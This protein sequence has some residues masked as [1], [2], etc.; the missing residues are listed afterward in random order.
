MVVQHHGQL[1]F[2]TLC[3]VFFVFFNELFQGEIQTYY[4]F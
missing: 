4:T 2:A 3:F 1:R